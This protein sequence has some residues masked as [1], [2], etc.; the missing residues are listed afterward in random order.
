MA[1]E[2]FSF[3][4]LRETAR[5]KPGPAESI[6]ADDGVIL[7]YRRYLPAS[8]VAVVLFYHGG[9][10]HS[11]AGYQYLSNSLQ[12]EY[13]IA[14]Y[15]PDIRGHGNSDG[16]RGDS[17]SPKQVWND[18]TTIIK[19]IRTEFVDLPLFLGGHS[20]G[21]GLALNYAGQSDKEQVSGYLFLSPQLGARSQTERISQN[22]PFA[23][24]NESDF[25]AY[26][27]SGGKLNGH[28]YAVRFNYPE[29]LLAAD[30]GLVAAITVNMSVSLIPYNP[31][32]QFAAIDRPFGLWIGTDD[33]LFIPDKVLA[34][35]SYAQL[36]QAG[37]IV[38]SIP[39]E[40][41]LSVLVTAHKT[42]GPWITQLLRTCQP[43][44]C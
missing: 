8:P 35:G 23:K 6:V 30:H 31:K 22:P 13:K 1:E 9:G 25:A 7:S 32:E 2:S 15:T 3:K 21:A 37:S 17:P 44:F 12:S 29:E 24:I 14:V 39:G 38:T 33:E 16:I 27:T 20:S 10:A 43:E 11:G 36:L 42:I 4:E 34:F 5:I 18:I 26:A 41:H 19:H 28:N 40:K